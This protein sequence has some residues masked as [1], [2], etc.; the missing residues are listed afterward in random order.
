MG[1]F[2]N[3]ICY[4]KSYALAMEIFLV[5]KGFPSEERFSLTGQI[6]RS[7]RSVC[8]NLGEAYR[9][10]RYKQHFLSKLND[11]ESE[12]LETEIWLDFAKECKYIS[13]EK[14]NQMIALNTEVG[15]LI[16]Y[17]IQNPEKFM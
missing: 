17:M 6:V 1:V 8:C 16:W 11:A 13:E 3:L 12:N 7:S 2:K 4:K 14:Y 9:R 10:K 15:K 5:S